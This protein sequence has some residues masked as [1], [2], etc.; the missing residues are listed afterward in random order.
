MY[1]KLLATLPAILATTAFAQPIYF[2]AND[3]RT[4]PAATV[5]I[6][7]EAEYPAD[8]NQ[9]IYFTANKIRTAS[10]AATAGTESKAA[11]YPAYL[12]QPI[13][14][15]ANKLRTGGKESSAGT[16]VADA[17]ATAGSGKQATAN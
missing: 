13:Y 5:G 7:S 4:N 16:K 12:N 10:A 3:L 6:K 17:T 1:Q 2:T 8:L 9:P 11:D 15:I 14:F